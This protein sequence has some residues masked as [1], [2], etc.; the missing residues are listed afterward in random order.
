VQFQPLIGARYLNLTERMSINGIFV[1]RFNPGSAPLDTSILSTA[2]N[3]IWGGQI[4]LRAQVNTKYLEFGATPKIMALGDTSANTVSAS[5][6]TVPNNGYVSQSNVTT[7]FTWGAEANAF[8]NI[9]LT[10]N[11]TVRTGYTVMWINQ[12]SR[13][14]KNV[15]Y[16][17]A[18]QAGPPIGLQVVLHDVLYYGFNFGCEFRF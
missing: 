2:M 4:G 11:F 3:N 1:D 8:V 10:Q 9:N 16:N 7:L 12:V 13:P 5:N 6:F 18:G 14:F 17:D 15:Y